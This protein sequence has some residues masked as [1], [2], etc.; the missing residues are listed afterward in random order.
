M[1]NRDSETR[2]PLAS[3]MWLRGIVVTSATL[4]LASC[5]EGVLDPHGPVGKAERVPMDRLMQMQ[6]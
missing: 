6:R 5:D 2:T 3:A 1:S 4:W